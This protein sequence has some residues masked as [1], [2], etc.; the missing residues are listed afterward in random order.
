MSQNKKNLVLKG[1][2][3]SSGIAIGKV[4]LLEDDDFFLIHKE[5]PKNAR[6]AE[7]QR[8]ESAIEK[9]RSELQIT[10]SKI[11]DVLGEN[12]AKIADVHLLILDDPVMKKIRL[13]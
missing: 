7:L 8:F 4:F 6:D 1:V 13:K 11:N 3:A 10:Y 5:I 9:T 12:Y 2:A